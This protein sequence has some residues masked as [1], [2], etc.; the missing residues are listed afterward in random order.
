MW[1]I[2][3]S[4]NLITSNIYILIVL[5]YYEHKRD[6]GGDLTQLYDENPYTNG[7]FKNPIDNTKTPPKLRLHTI[8]DRLRTVS[9]SNRHPTAV[10]KPV[11]KIFDTFDFFLSRAAMKDRRSI[12]GKSLRDF[13]KRECGPSVIHITMKKKK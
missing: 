2:C 12:W 4:M 6:K 5:C 8:S 13:L 7:K 10:V 3:L 9:W 1:C 11:Y